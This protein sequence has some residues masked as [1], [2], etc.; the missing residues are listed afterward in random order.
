[1]KR[2]FVGGALCAG[3]L[4]LCVQPAL[5]DGTREASPAHAR[6]AVVLT[7]E[8]GVAIYRGPRSLAG[9]PLAASAEDAAPPPQAAA[10]T[11]IVEHHYH[12]KI[13]HLRTQG[14]YSGHPGTSRRFTQGFYSG[15]ADKGRSAHRHCAHG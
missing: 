2:M 8:K 3:S 6:S 5:A 12:S 11:V 9:A 7:K 4:L 14:F 13:R 1:M 10:K 15:P